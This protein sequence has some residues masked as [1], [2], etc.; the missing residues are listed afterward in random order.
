MVNAV[1]IKSFLLGS[2]LSLSFETSAY[3]LS[4][5]FSFSNNLGNTSGTVSGII[6]GL[7]NNQTNQVATSVIIDNTFP[8][9]LTVN[10]GL[11]SGNDAVL[12]QTQFANSFDVINGEITRAKFIA[13]TVQNLEG[14]SNFLCIGTESNFCVFGGTGTVFTGINNGLSLDDGSMANTLTASDTITFTPNPVPFEFSPN[15]G[16]ILLGS[17]WL[18]NKSLKKFANRIEKSQ[19]KS[20]DL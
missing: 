4:F 17:G 11:I 8:L 15:L 19:S 13:A 7:E 18:A 6:I 9:G 14:S 5:T 16:F 3:A 12:W 2:L 20:D 10:N 1:L